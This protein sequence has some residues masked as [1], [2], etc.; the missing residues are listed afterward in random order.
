MSNAGALKA[1]KTFLQAAV[2]DLP[3]L[4]LT[5]MGKGT[6]ICSQKRGNRHSGFYMGGLCLFSVNLLHTIFPQ[7]N[8]VNT[9]MK[10]RRGIPI[11]HPPDAKL[12]SV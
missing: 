6:H 10:Y 8:K 1:N 12:T 3:S 5:D 7:C 4:G 2:V 9:A 11:I